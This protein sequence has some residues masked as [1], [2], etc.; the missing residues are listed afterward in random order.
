MKRRR[1]RPT[2][3]EGVRFWRKVYKLPSGKLADGCWLWM[4]K[5]SAFGYGIFRLGPPSRRLVYAH[6]WAYNHAKGTIPDGLEL[7][8]LCNC[9]SCVNPEHLEAVT[10]RENVWRSQ[11][12]TA[13]N[14]R[15]LHC[16]KGHPYSEDNTYR[17]P[18]KGW[19]YC[20]SCQRL[21]RTSTKS[22]KSA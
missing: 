21:K 16:P 17:L 19:R 7:D 22:K 2:T 6:R 3:D 5:R 20:R 10:P 14:H 11:G 12:V 18:G 8:H 9:P 13:A 1:G 15:K 4:A